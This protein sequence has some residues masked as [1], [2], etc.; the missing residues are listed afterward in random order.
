[1]PAE[2]T[3]EKVKAVEY[4]FEALPT[5][6]DTS[7]NANAGSTKSSSFLWKQEKPGITHF[8]IVIPVTAFSVIGSNRNPSSPPVH[9][10]VNKAQ[11]R[12]FYT[13]TK[14]RNFR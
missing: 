7:S 14:G 13:S 6:V 8:E 12:L 3:V 9:K 2:K 5:H 1:M 4:K 11:L 10:P